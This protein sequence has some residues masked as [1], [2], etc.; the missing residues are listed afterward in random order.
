MTSL[1]LSFDGSLLISAS[2]DGNCTVWDVISRQP[3]RKFESHKGPITH[4]SC[5]LR[6]SELVTGNSSNTSVPMPWK[7]FKR[8][9][10]TEEEEQ[11]TES[12]QLMMDT[13]SVGG[14]ILSLLSVSQN[15][16]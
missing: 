1:A 8:T 3:L 5:I 14:F 7:T 4:V 11:R 9:L 15:N 13:Q 2:E 12:F 16:Y 6:P 10:A